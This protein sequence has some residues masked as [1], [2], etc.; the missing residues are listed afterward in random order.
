MLI[1]SHCHLDMFEEPERS[2][3]VARAR[4]AGVAEMVTIGT[5]LAASDALRSIAEAHG[6]WAT[7]GVH[8]H[9]AAE[10]WNESGEGPSP[11]A[12]AAETKHARVVGIGES[13][14]DYF[15]DTA[16]RGVQQA[17]FRAHI[18]AARL[19][20]LPLVIHARDAD[21]DVE[22]ILRDERD[23][24]G[25]FAFLLHCFSSGRGL[26]EAAL[27]M[28]GY[29]SFSGILTFPRSEELRAI[30]RDV[31]EDRFLVETDSPYL[32]PVPLRGK[33]CEPAYVTHTAAKLAEVRGVS[34]ATLADQSTANFRRLFSRAA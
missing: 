25:D 17:G 28:G 20:G 24:G 21:A 16:P 6:V 10:Y 31:P 19:A 1:D 2:A 11:E 4:A 12:I 22:E 23:R 14:L 30:A 5:R 32:A 34:P 29:V 27:A 7:V 26:A 15:Y 18:R 9:Q 8:P 3:V 13:G 33:R